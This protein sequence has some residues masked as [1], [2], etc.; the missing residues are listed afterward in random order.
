MTLRSNPE[1]VKAWQARSA[2]R[3]RAKARERG[4]KPMPKSNRARRAR[5][6]ARNYGTR[7]EAV[8][9]AGCIAASSG[10]CEGPIEACHDRARGMGGAGGDRFELFGACSK[11]HRESG[12]RRSSQRAEFE[13]RHGVDVGDVVKATADRLTQEGHE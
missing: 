9:E 1:K 2:A 3:S 7:G 12:P 4:A 10:E 11:H 6:F 8:R 5:A 13:R